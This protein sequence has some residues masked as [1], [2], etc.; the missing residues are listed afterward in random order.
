MFPLYN[1]DALWYM[2]SKHLEGCL[3][4]TYF[5]AAG[6]RDHMYEIYLPQNQKLD[7]R[8]SLY[9]WPQ[10]PSKPVVRCKAPGEPIVSTTGIR[11]TT[12][13]LFHDLHLQGLTVSARD[14]ALLGNTEVHLARPRSIQPG[15]LDQCDGVALTVVWQRKAFS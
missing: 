6:A 8:S 7:T 3:L 2:Y 13:V 1:L 15:T 4:Q 10:A 11:S 9:K 5:E 14:P 12:P